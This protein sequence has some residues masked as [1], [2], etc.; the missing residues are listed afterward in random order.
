MSF[1][2]K[3]AIVTGAG[4]GIGE[5]SAKRLAR[6][7]ASVVVADVTDEGG[8]RVVAEIRA[9]GGTAEYKRTDIS[10]ETDVADLVAFTVDTF[11]GLHLA[12]NNAGITHAPTPIEAFD[13]GVWQ[14]VQDIDTTGTFLCL[15]AEIAHM[16]EHGGGAI[17]NTAS[18]AG[19]KAAP[20]LYSYV[21][22]KHAVVG[23]TRVAALEYAP[24]GIRVNAVAPGTIASP[25][26][27]TMPQE[28][29][30][31]YAGMMPMGRLGRPEEVADLAAYL[32]SD[33]ASY[34]TGTVVEVDGGYMQSSKGQ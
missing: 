22:A 34:V 5:A 18:G 28:L 15:R 31:L 24:K 23:L 30:D 9:D 33:E 2:G 21:A 8:T 17:V 27:L 10:S 12:H 32:L 19:L 4:S 6:L 7:G 25:M 1:E 3:V 11:G 13:L 14:R 20:G 26:V 29:Q 16:V